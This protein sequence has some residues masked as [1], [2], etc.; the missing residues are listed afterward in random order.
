MQSLWNASF[1]MP[2]FKLLGCDPTASNTYLSQLVFSCRSERESSTALWPHQALPWQSKSLLNWTVSLLCLFVILMN[3]AY[4][5]FGTICIHIHLHGTKT[6]EIHGTSRS[7]WLL[8]EVHLRAA[9][10]MGVVLSRSSHVHLKKGDVE[11]IV[12]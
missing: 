7:R 6:H 9:S 5:W 1:Q 4:G 12:I 2:G 10:I 11:V 8:R 3:F